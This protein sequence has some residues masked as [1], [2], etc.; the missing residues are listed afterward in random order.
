[1]MKNEEKYHVIGLMSGT[2]LD[3]V[4]IAYVEFK[5]NQKWKFELGVCEMIPYTEEWRNLLYNLH[6]QSD[7]KIQKI[8]IKYGLFLG[9][10]IKQFIH[11]NK[12]QVD[13]ICSHGHTIFHQPKNKLTLQ[14][15]DGQSIANQTLK[16][17]ICDFRSMDVSLGGQGAPLVPIGDYLLFENYNYYLNLGGFS[18]VSYQ[19]NNIRKA[20]DICPLNIILNDLAR[21]LGRPYDKNGEIARKGRRI[22]SLFHQLNELSYY[23]LKAPKS[24]AKEW[25]EQYINP[26][27]KQHSNI[28]DLLNTFTEHAA[29]QIGKNLQEGSCLITGGGAFNSYLIERLQSYTKTDIHLPNKKIIEYKEALIFAFLGVL[30]YR[31]EINCLSSVTGAK[32]DC[33]GGVIFT[34]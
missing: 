26:L 11:N 25:V 32:S 12:I 23:S 7:K 34:R 24:L 17:V 1:M 14:I 27:L 33:S 8:N 20:Y 18:N 4:D 5:F 10:L 19:K 2:S 6:K 13:F 31:N 28:P 30:R 29:L 16:K 22:D 3:G 15:G 9:K 21:Q